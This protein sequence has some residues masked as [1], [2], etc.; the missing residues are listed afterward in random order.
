MARTPSQKPEPA[1]DTGVL[2]DIL[3][4]LDPATAQ[5]L[6]DEIARLQARIADLGEAVADVGRA[7]GAALGE[8][9]KAAA[10]AGSARFAGTRAE[11]EDFARDRPGQALLA[12]GGVGL[13][14]GLL[15]ARR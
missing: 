2:D 5:T 9:A 8:G 14:L 13:L 6:R 4:R 15:L 7:G 11:V 3:S 12:A 1:A 10:E